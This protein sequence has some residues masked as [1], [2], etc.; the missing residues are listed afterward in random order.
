VLG[1]F[2]R[3]RRDEFEGE[4]HDT[5][6]WLRLGRDPAAFDVGGD[7]FRQAEALWKRGLRASTDAP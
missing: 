2:K 5:G 7:L 1:W 4:H 6:I 3:V